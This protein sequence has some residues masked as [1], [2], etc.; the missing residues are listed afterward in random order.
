MS[1]KVRRFNLVM[2]RLIEG[3]KKKDSK[4]LERRASLRASFLVL[5]YRIHGTESFATRSMLVSAILDR[6]IQ[7]GL[8]SRRYHPSWVSFHEIN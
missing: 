4:K 2:R 5:L 3:G 7:P 8:A 6:R 1:V